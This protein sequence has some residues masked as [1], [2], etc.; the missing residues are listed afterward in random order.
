MIPFFSVVIPLYNKQNYIENTIQSVL[1]QQFKSFELIIV[2]DCSTDNS[3]LILNKF[4]DPR[5]IIISHTK[6]KGLS[7]TRNS[8][9]KNA[10]TNYIAFLDADD[11]WKSNFLDEIYILIHKYPRASIFATNYEEILHQYMAILPSNGAENLDEI[12]IISNYFETCLKQPLYCPSSMCVKKEVFENIGLFDENITYGEDVD[13]NIRA[14]L[15]YHLAYS[16]N[17]LV[18]YIT[19]SEN[20]ITRSNFSSKKIT[21]LD[22]YEKYDYPGLKKFLDFQ[23]YT[24]AKMYKMEGNQDRYYQM[25]KKICLKNLNW[26]QIILLYL[27]GFV[28]QKIKIY[29]NKKLATGKRITSYS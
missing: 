2:D 19:E 7:A 15:F 9:I 26:K 21:D 11:L 5:I 20:Q 8:G 3:R 27:P 10:T 4:N 23:R 14:N 24:K 29:K 17:A 12:S 22:F 28:L 18:Q 1:N 13:F 6:N 25:K 16:K